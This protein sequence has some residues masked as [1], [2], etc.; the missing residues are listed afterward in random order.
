MGIIVGVTEGQ[1]VGKTV[2][3]AEGHKDGLTLGSHNKKI[4]SFFICH[5]I[6]PGK[7]ANPPSSIP[8]HQSPKIFKKFERATSGSHIPIFFS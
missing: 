1:G 6:L 4:T 5:I 3:L 2:G 7:V 8:N